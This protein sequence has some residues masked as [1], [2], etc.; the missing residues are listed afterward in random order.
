MNQFA[1]VLMCLFRL[2]PQ[3][4][5]MMERG[6]QDVSSLSQEEILVQQAEHMLQHKEKQL[7]SLREKYL[8]AVSEE[9]QRAIELLERVRRGTGSPGSDTSPEEMEKDLDEMLYQVKV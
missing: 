2:V 7:I 1:L 3:V 5:D 6:L 8:P 9:R 4:H